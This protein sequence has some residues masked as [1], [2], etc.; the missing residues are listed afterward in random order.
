MF[1]SDAGSLSLVCVSYVRIDITADSRARY[2]EYVRAPRRHRSAGE[3]EEDALFSSSWRGAK[4][5]YE[6]STIARCTSFREALH[7]L[8]K[9]IRDGIKRSPF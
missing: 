4:H 6:Y 1:L 9:R 7:K 8:R 3:A 2:L 5:I